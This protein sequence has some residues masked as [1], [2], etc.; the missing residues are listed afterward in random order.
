MT[1]ALMPCPFCGGE[2]YGPYDSSSSHTNDL[3][4]AC[5]TC[6]GRV[7]VMYGRGEDGMA[8]AIAA[9][10]RRVHAPQPGKAEGE[11]VGWTAADVAAYRDQRDYWR[12][13]AG[14]AE[15]ELDALHHPPTPPAR[16]G[17]AG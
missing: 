6:D 3:T 8:K 13:R 11:D 12:S 14:K 2:P 9:W 4:I 7:E 5:N 15:A 10:N 1:D 16:S 17:E